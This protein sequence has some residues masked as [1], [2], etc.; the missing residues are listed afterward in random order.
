MKTIDFAIIGGSYAGMAAA[1]QLARARRRVLVVDAGRR[2]NRFV[3]AAGGASHG[4]LTQDGRAPAEIAADAREQLM[5]YPN[6][7]WL[8]GVA[9]DARLDTDGALSFKVGMERV[10]ARRLIIATGVQDEL[11]AVPGLADRWGRT[12]FHCPYCHGYEADAG[13]IGIIAASAL[14]LHQGLMLPDWG[15]TTL[16]LNDSY[17]PSDQDMAAMIRRGTRI[18]PVPIARIAGE[19]D[20]VLKDGRTVSMNTLFT[21]PRVS[22]TSPIAEQLG[23]RIEAGPMGPFIHVDESKATSIPHVF[24]CGDA[25]RAAGNVTLAVADGAMAAFAAHRQSMV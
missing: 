24:A 5:N 9:D 14:A 11:P 2:R 13:P 17:T 15:P 16:F 19:A 4:F 18:E 21:Q 10:R 6:V 3:D 12:V 8:H 23:C 20:V 1:L 7:E 22:L 25:A